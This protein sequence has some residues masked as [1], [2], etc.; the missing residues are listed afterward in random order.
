MKKL[1]SI[2]ILLFSFLGA[3]SGTS[4]FMSLQVPRG[5]TSEYDTLENTT[6]FTTSPNAFIKYCQIGAIAKA[7]LN[8]DLVVSDKDTSIFII[9]EWVNVSWMFTEKSKLFIDNGDDNIKS[10]ELDWLANT[11]QVFN[12]ERVIERGIIDDKIIIP[13]LKENLNYDSKVTIRYMGEGQRDKKLHKKDIQKLID[14]I[15][16]YEELKSTL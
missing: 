8:I 1:F 5:I 16:F 10:I 2:G 11:R 15:Y 6:R 14:M 7:H 3:S 9:N 13:F 12:S 4:I